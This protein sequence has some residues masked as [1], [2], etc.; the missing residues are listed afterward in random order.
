MI[1]VRKIT[2]K[3]FMYYKNMTI[4]YIGVPVITISSRVMTFQSSTS[5]PVIVNFPSTNLSVIFEILP[6]S[7]LFVKP[8]EA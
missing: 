5:L 3:F 8:T 6:A 1:L 7:N 2:R 4:Y